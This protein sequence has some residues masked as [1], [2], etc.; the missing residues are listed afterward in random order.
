M[1]R[2][3]PILL[4]VFF[5]GGALSGLPAELLR[6]PYL[7]LGTPS[8]V[9]VNW[10]TDVPTDSLV[11]YGASPANLISAAADLNPT[12]EHAVQ[13]SGLTPNTKYYYSIGSAVERLA[14]GDPD[15]S[16]ITHPIPGQAKPTRIWAIGDSGTASVGV[17]GSHFVRD[18]YLALN[19]TN[20]TDVWLMLGDNAYYEGWDHEYQTAV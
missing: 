1:K 3:K 16:F 2:F 19:G 13:I 14:G 5:L 12:T 11:L 8:S 15:H 17:F 4:S 6:G 10:R 20:H 9:I 18:A 7:Q